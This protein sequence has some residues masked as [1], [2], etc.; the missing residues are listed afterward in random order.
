MR[1][2]WLAAYESTCKQPP[3][4]TR[5][6]HLGCLLEIR[7]DM[8]DLTSEM[9]SDGKINV[10]A[11][12]PMTIAMGMCTGFTGK[13]PETPTVPMIPNVP[14]PPIPPMPKI[15]VPTPPQPSHGPD[16]WDVPTPD[17]ASPS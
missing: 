9:E 4:A 5:H 11:I 8:R 12:I 2:K 6:E 17:H 3:S 15:P 7:D 16:P 1:A 10:G 14:T 13:N